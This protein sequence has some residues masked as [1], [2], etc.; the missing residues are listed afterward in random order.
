MKKWRETLVKLTTTALMIAMSI[1]LC[2]L[3]GFPQ[4]GIYRIELGFLPIAVVA[5]LYGPVLSGIAYGIAD[6]I[7]AAIFTGINPFITL[8]K[9]LF[10]VVMGLFFYRREKISLWRNILCFLIIGAAIDIVCMSPIFVYMFGN[11]WKEALVTR[12]IATLVNT[13]ARIITFWLVFRYLGEF[14]RRY[15]GKHKTEPAF[16]SYANGFQAVPRLGL[17]RMLCMTEIAGHPE[18]RLHCIH[19]AGTNGKGSVC[20]FLESMLISAGYRVGKYISPNLVRVNERIT[21]NGEEITDKALSSLLER[22]EAASVKTERRIKERPS[23]FEIWTM[24]AFCYFAEKECDY[25]IL[26]TGLGG[27]FDATNVIDGNVMAVLTH[28]DLDHMQYL[29]DTVE[30]IAETKSKIIKKNCESG[31]AVSS[32]QYPGVLD[33]LKKRAEECGIRLVVPGEAE[34]KGFRDIYEIFSYDG[35]EDMVCGLGGPHQIENACTAVECARVL[36][37]NDEQIRFGIEHAKNP[38]RFEKLSDHPAVIYDGAHNPDGTAALIRAMDRYFPGTSRTVVFACMR[39]K[40]YLDSLRML[41]RADVTKFIFTTVS[42]NERA[43]TAQ[44]LTAAASDAGITGESAPTLREALEIAK[45]YGNP[46]FIC[47]SLYLYADL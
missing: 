5:M 17:E 28:I 15:A 39:D 2:R 22:M 41:E 34:V 18:A 33:V 45:S 29:G 23:Q 3:L 11:P 42:G 19:I 12:G 14:L 9:I 26:E 8:C 38:A 31:V 20:A 6:L 1:I 30:K 40:D 47:G 27:E 46:V 21:I 36:G 35:L 25:V 44:A 37:L 13:P 24:A 7:G 10:G 32:H 43:M 4:S 16:S